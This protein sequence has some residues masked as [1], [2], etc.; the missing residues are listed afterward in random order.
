M[1]QLIHSRIDNTR[2][3]IKRLANPK[4]IEEHI[5]RRCEMAVL[6]E[7]IE[8]LAAAEERVACKDCGLHEGHRSRCVQ[9]MQPAGS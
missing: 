7:L 8:L 2:A 9:S 1:L 4:T 6:D 5:E 3:Q